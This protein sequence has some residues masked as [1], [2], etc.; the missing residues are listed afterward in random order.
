MDP[1]GSAFVNQLRKRSTADVL[2]SYVPTSNTA[3]EKR[4]KKIERARDAEN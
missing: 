4:A 1:N 3:R 2:P